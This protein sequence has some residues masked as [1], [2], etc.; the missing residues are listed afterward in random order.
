MIIIAHC[1]SCNSRRDIDEDES[2]RLTESLS[3]PLCDQCGKPTFA[4]R[5]RWV[6]QGGSAPHERS[7]E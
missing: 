4:V 7:C 1:L 2:K 3:I 5:A 6:K